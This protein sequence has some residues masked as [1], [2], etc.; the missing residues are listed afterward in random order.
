MI[1]Y[2]LFKLLY[3]ILTCNYW[4]TL[5]GSDSLSISWYLTAI[6]TLI[7]LRL[8]N[9]YKTP[10]KQY[11]DISEAQKSKTKT[12]G[13]KGGTPHFQKGEDFK[14]IYYLLNTEISDSGLK[15]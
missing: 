11:A 3:S 13:S 2:I 1:H 6:D 10:Q 9:F 8:E 12:C 15:V 4:E 7:S 5:V 14:N